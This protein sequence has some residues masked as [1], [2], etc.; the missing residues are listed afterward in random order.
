MSRRHSG[1][2]RAKHPADLQVD[3]NLMKEVKGK[4]TAQGIT[5]Q[6]AHGIASAMA[7]APHQV[8]VAIDMHNG[9]INACQLGLFGYGKVKR[10]AQAGPEIPQELKTAVEN[11]LVDGHLSCAEAWRIADA[12]GIAR[13]EVGRACEFLGIK[14]R[15]CQLGA[16]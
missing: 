12:R 11:S 5:C 13:M 9:R 3:E 4:L 16:F 1:D 6:S 7:V 2:F 10:I 15:Q 14:I 8:G